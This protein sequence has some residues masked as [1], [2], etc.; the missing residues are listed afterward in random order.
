VP[1]RVRASRK[2]WGGSDTSKLLRFCEERAD[3]GRREEGSRKE[4]SREEGKR[5]KQGG[6]KEGMRAESG[7][8]GEQHTGGIVEGSMELLLPGSLDT[9]IAMPIGR[10]GP[11]DWGH[12]RVGLVLLVV[13][14]SRS[15]GVGTLGRRG[16]TGRLARRAV[17]LWSGGWGLGWDGGGTCSITC[18]CFL[19]PCAPFEMESNTLATPALPCA[20]LM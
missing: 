12:T 4:R 18:K 6:E 2:G 14:R 13:L 16:G 3:E 7:A 9:D 20:V 15:R 11:R 10:E 19:A 17:V 8:E 1:L 5:E